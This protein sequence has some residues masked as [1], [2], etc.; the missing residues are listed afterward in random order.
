MTLSL[1]TIVG[2]RGAARHAPE[3][4]LVS[5]REAARQ[6]APWVEI[7]VH[8]NRDKVPVL[9]HDHTLDRTTD[10]TGRVADKT[11]A[12]LKALDAGSWFDAKF[13]GERIPTLEECLNLCL[14]LGL[15]INIE[16]KPTPGQEVETAEVALE[17]AQRVW[18]K[19]VQAPLISSFAVDSLM[20]AK[21]VAPGWP[22]GYLLDERPADWAAVA[23][24]I[25]AATMNVNHR[26]ENAASIGEYLATGRPVLVYT[27]ND[28]QRAAEM[29]AM[30]VTTV[31][32]D[33]PTA[34]KGAVPA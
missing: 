26:R 24:R 31:I 11:L 15:L 17:L 21:R 27:V 2:H 34:L 9:I 6:G 10:G 29:W 8:L 18:P 3:N 32:T 20:A 28:A 13:A 1:P 5:I 14:E 33:T 12:E 16:I 19:N 30:D 23:D 22:R 7:D 4:T 25:G